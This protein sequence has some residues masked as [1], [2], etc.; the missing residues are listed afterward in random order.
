MFA[1]RKTKFQQIRN[2]QTSEGLT[3][4]SIYRGFSFDSKRLALWLSIFLM[5][6]IYE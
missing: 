4:I 5:N 3:V 1:E 2:S 6:H